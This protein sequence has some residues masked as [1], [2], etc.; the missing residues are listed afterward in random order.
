MSTQA[1]T[2]DSRVNG[3]RAAAGRSWSSQQTKLMPRG[4]TIEE[5]DEDDP[6]PRGQSVIELLRSEPRHGSPLQ[7]HE[8]TVP[9]VILGSPVPPEPEV[10]EWE[11]GSPTLVSEPIPMHRTSR[12]ASE[13]GILETEVNPDTYRQ[14][15]HMSE[16]LEARRETRDLVNFLQTTAPPSASVAPDFP[17]PVSPPQ[18][19]GALPRFKNILHRMSSTTKRQTYKEAKEEDNS[20]KAWAERT[21]LPSPSIQTLRSQ[22]DAQS[23]N[24]AEAPP[25]HSR[26]PSAGLRSQKSQSSVGSASTLHGHSSLPSQTRGQDPQSSTAPVTTR[27]VLRRASIVRKWAAGVTHGEQKTS[28]TRRKSTPLSVSSPLAEDSEGVEDESGDQRGGT[29]SETGSLNSRPGLGLGLG[30]TALSTLAAGDAAM[31]D[32]EKYDSDNDDNNNGTPEAAL[33]TLTAGSRSSPAL[34]RPTTMFRAGSPQHA[35]APSLTAVEATPA[36]TD[37]PR[38][39][40]AQLQHER[41]AELR[42]AEDAVPSAG[43]NGTPGTPVAP[44]RSASTRSLGSRHSAS[45]VLERRSLP[46][47]SPASMST[48]AL[49]GSSSPQPSSKAGSYVGL[50]KSGASVSD[51]PKASIRSLPTG[52]S[53]GASASVNANATSTA[54][55]AAAPS[56]GT[57]ARSSPA[58]TAAPLPHDGCVALADLTPLRHL[59]DHATTAR[60]CQL[61]LDAILSQLGVPRAGE[62]SDR[63]AAWLLGGSPMATNRNW[64]DKVTRKAPPPPSAGSAAR[65]VSLSASSSSMRSP[66]SRRKKLGPD[67]TMKSLPALPG[68]TDRGEVWDITSEPD[69]SANG[70]GNGHAR[71]ERKDKAG[72]AGDVAVEKPKV[73]K[74]EEEAAEDEVTADVLLGEM[75]VDDKEIDAAAV[76]AGKAA[77]AGV[78]TRVLMTA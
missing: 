68:D 4:P 55:V 61:L 10:P 73:E 77:V 25:T 40:G 3:Y 64:A 36:M 24:S 76:E 30:I 43:A 15:R 13:G 45:P 28:L 41:V 63:V 17:R 29:G 59:L 20:F 2:T 32:G 21:L 60:E 34:S 65:S 72:A 78:D 48:R 57:S 14:P 5:K 39:T 69:V 46:P 16:R 66:K 42:E 58:S 53:A 8:R 52:S 51:S 19:R 71:E 38:S 70:N 26:E 11:A 49:P 12:S 75:A 6:N 56:V 33:A 31:G 62:G 23:H 18:Q 37:S 67:A 35:D 47:R 27:E 50:S 7:P 74:A 1:S 9:A 54:R 22:G 44:S